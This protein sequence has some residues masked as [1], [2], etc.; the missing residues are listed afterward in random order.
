MRTRAPIR[1]II[2]QTGRAR[3]STIFTPQQ[4][5]FKTNENLYFRSIQMAII[6]EQECEIALQLITTR[7]N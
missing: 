6:H 5:N 7:N 4:T 3:H 1:V 2:K